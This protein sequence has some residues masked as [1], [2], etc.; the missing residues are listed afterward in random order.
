MNAVQRGCLFTLFFCAF[1]FRGESQ[2]DPCVDE[3]LVD[4]GAICP[5]VFD[6]VCGCNGISY[7]NACEAQALGGVLQWTEGACAALPCADLAGIDLASVKWPWGWHASMALVNLSV[8]AV[9][10]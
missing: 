8:D 5:T 6:P 2:V 3:S 4:P 7:S 10:W 9:L 1:V